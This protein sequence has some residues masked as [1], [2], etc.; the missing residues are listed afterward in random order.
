MNFRLS[1]CVTFDPIVSSELND[2]LLFGDY[3]DFFFAIPFISSKITTSKHKD[4]EGKK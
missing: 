1:A 4:V 3:R 2:K